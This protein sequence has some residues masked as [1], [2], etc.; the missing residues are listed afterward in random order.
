MN[1]VRSEVFALCFVL[2]H[3]WVIT[4]LKEQTGYGLV[5]YVEII[6]EH[7]FDYGFLIKHLVNRGTEFTAL[8]NF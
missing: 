5:F 4:I 1:S 3:P 6:N 7:L 2:L 8:M